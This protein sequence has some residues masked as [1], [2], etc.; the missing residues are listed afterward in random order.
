MKTMKQMTTFEMVLRLRFKALL[1]IIRNIT[2]QTTSAKGEALLDLST[3]HNF[4][5]GLQKVPFLFLG[6]T[7]AYF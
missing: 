2:K 7:L 6:N 1:A 3:I 4:Q 5:N